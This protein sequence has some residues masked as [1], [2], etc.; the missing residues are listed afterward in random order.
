M[1]IF[2]RID[3]NSLKRREMQLWILAVGMIVVLSAGIALLMFPMAYS[4]PVDLTGLPARAIFFGFCAMS[5]LMIGYFIDRQLV[6]RQLR[7]ELDQKAHQVAAMRLEASTDLLNSIPGFTIFR[8]RL[9]M[10]HRRAANT[11][12]P[13][14]LVTVELKP[15]HTLRGAGEA[16]VAFGDAAKTLTAKMRGEDAL[17][18]LAPGIFGVLL[19]GANA[20]D[21]YRVRDHITEGLHDAAGVSNRFSFS[22][23]ALNYP[24]HA[25]SAREM[26]GYIQC[27]LPKDEDF[28]PEG[29]EELAVA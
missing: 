17:F 27:L 28:L 13:L 19:P 18:Q 4:H 15:S 20:S 25:S 11:H 22:V 10:E 14:S 16:E 12:Q 2:D 24:D 7:A 29:A 23:N 6:I 5:A 3:N 8:D 21:G 1:R 26:E 9:A